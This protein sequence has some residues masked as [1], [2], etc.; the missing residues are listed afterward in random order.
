MRGSE[1]WTGDD[2]RLARML[3][4]GEEVDDWV[5]AT[6]RGK[7]RPG[8][9][10]DPPAV[11]PGPAPKSPGPKA[12]A[13]APV[14][15]RK[16]MNPLPQRLADSA[17]V[18]RE[19]RTSLDEENR[20]QYFRVQKKLRE[21]EK[22]EDQMRQGVML[23]GNQREKVDRKYLLVAEL[24]K[25][26]VPADISSAERD[27]LLA[28]VVA[29]D[30][31]I[32]AGALN[33]AKLLAEQARL[34]ASGRLTS[35]RHAPSRAPP[36]PVEDGWGRVGKSGK[37]EL[38]ELEPRP[39]APKTPKTP[40]VSTIAPASIGDRPAPRP[41]PA[42]PA[43]APPPSAPPRGWAQRPDR[44]EED[45]ADGAVA[46]ASLVAEQERL[47][48]AALRAQQQQVDTESALRK[49]GIDIDDRVRRIIAETADMDA[50]L[51]RIF[52]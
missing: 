33:E 47:Q 23:A 46:Q 42:R 52:A 41:A 12:P 22:L 9:H 34:A 5:A 26:P 24:R 29:Q 44:S 17:G 43:P 19:E 10:F 13:P 4:E 51:E 39:Q 6:K 40:V 11:S 15:D 28:V 31:E 37:K 3:N 38:N 14:T 32:E 48:R 8:A 1:P 50:A 49:M 7:P 27:A 16:A 18:K 20:R 35:G 21:I 30:A 2:E 25:L 36:L 45:G